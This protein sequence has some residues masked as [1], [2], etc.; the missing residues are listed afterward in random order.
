MRQGTSNVQTLVQEQRQQLS[1]IQLLAAQLTAL[2][3]EE[4]RARI[5]TE[6]S[7]NPWLERRENPN[8]DSLDGAG[9][10]YGSEA[11]REDDYR[12]SPDEYAA[13][14]DDDDWGGD[15]FPQASGNDEHF[16]RE[17]GDDPTFYDLLI[18]QLGEY[19]LTER[20]R[21]LIEYLIGS[22]DDDGLLRTPLFQISDELFIYRNLETNE[23]ELE[24]LLTQYLHEFEPYGV[25]AR[26]LV[27]C[28]LIQ[29][30]HKEDLP[31]RRQ[32]L[33]LFEQYAD[34]FRKNHWDVI[35][36]KM[37]LS[38]AE[39]SAMRHALLHLNPRPGGSVGRAAEESAQLIVPDFEVENDGNGRLSFRLHEPGIPLL[40]MS[41]DL[42]AELD[43]YTKNDL[44]NA[45]RDVVE[46]LRYKRNLFN[47]GSLFINALA[48]R[49]QSLLKV[50]NSILKRQM[51]YFQEGDETMLRP[52]TMTEVAEETGLD[53]STVS[54]VCQS[55]SVSTPYGTRPLR[56]FFTSKATKEGI[57]V[58]VR[59][60]LASLK[61]LIDQEDKHAPLSDD[62]LTEQLNKQGYAV[63]RR[64]IAKYREQLGIPSTRL[65]RI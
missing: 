39:L 59:D 9:D 43:A 34:E 52:M 57:D 19:D 64:T 18:Q 62:K 55:K 23:R 30:R 36:R 45:R 32:L 37:K 63:A 35:Q 48:Q 3:V 33:T 41:D 13:S 27:E 31:M 50:M 16:S 15:E 42:T 20:Q 22:I 5:E 53:V 44:S 24:E 49:R 21:A 61:S 38:E 56:W 4:L 11:D 40:E 12:E 65:R 14:G 60:M 7:E 29:V 28:L 1:A 26:D 46:A 2:S 54:R 25:G 10:G 51:P 6:C 58:S 8:D 17:R 47:N